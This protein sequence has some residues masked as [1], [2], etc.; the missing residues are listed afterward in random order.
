MKQTCKNLLKVFVA[1]FPLFC[2]LVLASCTN[3]ASPLKV[4][5]FAKD[6]HKQRYPEVKPPESAPVLKWDFSKPG[7]L[8]AYDYIQKS[9][10]TSQM[11]LGASAPG[12]PGNM[13]QEMDVHGELLIKSHGDHTAKMVLQNCKITTRYKFDK[14]KPEES[15][16]LDNPPIVIDGMREDGSRNG[17]MCAPNLSLE[18]FFTLPARALKVGQSV[19]RPAEMPFNAYGSPL[20]VTGTARITLT[21]Y[22]KIGKRICARL[23]VMTDISKLKVPPEI[24]GAYTCTVSGTGVFYFD[25]KARKFVSGEMASVMQIK[26][27]NAAPQMK[28]SGHVSGVT[29]RRMKASMTND[30]LVQMTLKD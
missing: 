5:E 24:K 1:V 2:L 7:S 3:A 23:D 15:M 13:G 22:V 21:R 18:D 20:K 4:S 27:D 19:T 9:R 12:A 11:D 29:P 28:F 17:G 8:Y 16:D 14:N 25:V 10:S 26:G 6:I 30:S